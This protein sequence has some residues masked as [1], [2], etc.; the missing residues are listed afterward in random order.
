MED[1]GIDSDSRKGLQDDAES[2]SSESVVEG[3]DGRGNSYVSFL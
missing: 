1:S 2:T 3:A